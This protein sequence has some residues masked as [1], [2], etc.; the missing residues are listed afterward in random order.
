MLVDSHC[1]LDSGTLAAE[2]DQ[3]VARAHA[4]GVGLMVTICT[5]P[6]HLSE[7]LALV[8]RY[9]SVY[10]AVGVHP[11]YV[12]EEG[13]L[14][15]EALVELSRHPRLVGIGETGLDYHYDRSPRELQQASFRNHIRAARLAGLPFIVHSR[16]ADADTAAILSEE[17]SKGPVS[18]V[19]HCFS[20]GRD[21]ALKAVGLGLY[22]SLAG[23]VTFANSGALRD[24]VRELPMDRLL[25]ETDAPYLAPVPMRGKR[26]EPAF[27]AHTAATMAQ[28]KAVT[29]AEFERQSTGNF[30]RL[31]NKIPAK[32][33]DL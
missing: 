12:A 8:E 3:V 16:N 2:L 20:S 14:P 24:T 1:H 7:V 10:C 15:V 18:G 4:A 19:M 5:R 32:V 9:P 13:L 25:V 29:M 21:L 17:L 22:V 23:I 26:N 31:F 28:L 33:P 11:H 30:F 6:K 27:V